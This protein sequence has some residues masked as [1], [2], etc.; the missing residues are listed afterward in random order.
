[1]QEQQVTIKKDEWG[2]RYTIG[3]T[4]QDGE[5][6]DTATSQ[7]IVERFNHDQEI[8][9]IILPKKTAVIELHDLEQGI[10]IAVGKQ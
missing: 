4:E 6:L 8:Y 1:M 3:G 10:A 2:S 7:N 5:I 9:A